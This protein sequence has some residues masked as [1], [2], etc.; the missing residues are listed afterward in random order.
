MLTLSVCRFQPFQPTTHTHIPHLKTHHYLHFLP[1]S[2]ACRQNSSGKAKSVVTTLSL[3]WPLTKHSSPFQHYFKLY[4]THYHTY[5]THTKSHPLYMPNHSD[6]ILLRWSWIEELRRNVISVVKL[7]RMC[8]PRCVTKCVLDLFWRFE[9][10]N[11]CF[12]LMIILNG[13]EIGNNWKKKILNKWRIE[14]V[15]YLAVCILWVG[16]K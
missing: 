14:S 2:T 5:A 8:S 9:S 12:G 4:P 11:L 7:W 6:H 15:F 10:W 16:W 13:N 1:I 3:F